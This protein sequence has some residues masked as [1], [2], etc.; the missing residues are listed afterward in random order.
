MD[1]E[2]CFHC[3]IE[4]NKSEEILYDD[5]KFCC[6]G[7]KTVYEI[8]SQHDLTCYYDFQSAPGATPQD[9]QG[10]YD[11]LNNEEASMQALVA[12]QK[13]N[14]SQSFGQC[15]TCKFFTIA[16]EAFSCGLTK[17]QLSHSDSEKICQEHCVL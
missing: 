2:N 12:L 7:C 16:S 10:K 13:A 8:F 3:G 1:T 4:F 6:N 11:F 15:K 9:I 5:K 14:K 17:E